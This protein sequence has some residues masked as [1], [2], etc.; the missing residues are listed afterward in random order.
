MALHINS[1]NNQISNLLHYYFDKCYIIN[2]LG[3]EVSYLFPI[4]YL[5]KVSYVIYSECP[6]SIVNPAV[7]SHQVTIQGH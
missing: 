4:S 1:K 5:C 2:L 3:L 7:F 6:Y